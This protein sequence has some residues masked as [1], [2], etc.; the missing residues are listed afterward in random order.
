MQRSWT[1]GRKIAAGFAISIV[2]LAVIGAVAYRSLGTLVQ[3]SLTVQHTHQVLEHLT[4]LLSQ[5]T[6]VETGGRGFAITGD[7]RFLE[8]YETVVGEV[9]TTVKDLR[10]LTVDNPAH[11]R[12]LG[13]A[14]PLVNAKLTVMRETIDARRIGLDSAV[15]K[16][17]SGEGRR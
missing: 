8:T 1:F 7:A 15:K 6:E 17:A 2:L 3:T 10:T 13:E 12:R 9:G 5:L 14:E 16:V 11:Q 4:K